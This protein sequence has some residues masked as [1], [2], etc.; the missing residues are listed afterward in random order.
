MPGVIIDDSQLSSSSLSGT[1]WQLRTDQDGAFNRTVTVCD[2]ASNGTGTSRTPPSIRFTFTGTQINLVGRPAAD[3]RMNY[4]IDESS[5]RPAVLNT[6]QDVVGKDGVVIWSL[7]GLGPTSSHTVQLFPVAGT[8]ALDYLSYLPSG[9]LAR[10]RDMLVVDNLDPQIRFSGSWNNERD[11][12]AAAGIPL[13]GTVSRTNSVGASFQFNFTGSAVT[14]YALRRSVAGRLSASYR[15]D[16]GT[17]ETVVHFNGSQDTQD[18]WSIN[19]AFF[20]KDLVPSTHSLTVTVTEVSANQEFAFDYLT[21]EATSY[22]RFTGPTPI[23][24]SSSDRSS[25]SGSRINLGAII[26]SVIAVVLIAYAVRWIFKRR[27]TYT[28]Q[29]PQNQSYHLETTQVYTQ[30]YGGQ[31]GQPAYEGHGYRQD[32]WPAPPPPYVP[33]PQQQAPL[34]PQASGWQPPSAPPPMP[35]PQPWQSHNAGE[36]AIP[37]PVV[38]H[39]PPHPVPSIP[40]I[41]NVNA[42]QPQI[43]GS[44]PT[45]PA[46][47][48]LPSLSLLSPQ[49]PPP[50]PAAV[51]QPQPR[52][53]PPPQ[54]QAQ[55]DGARSESPE[56]E[57]VPLEQLGLAPNY[58]PPAGPPPPASNATGTTT[59]N[60]RPNE[61]GGGA[62]PPFGPPGGGASS[63]QNPGPRSSL[64]GP[65]PYSG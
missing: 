44:P 31:Q 3:L 12:S 11:F 26:G 33:P 16:N 65:P 48:P 28:P 35:S 55:Q 57:E 13:N 27:N 49:P 52:A 61:P 42:Q 43:G 9:T 53:P 19:Q 36:V 41:G 7:D 40:N 8:L 64:G 58:P 56:L 30:P 22:T 62:P 54:Q 18:R 14:V 1:Q 63:G 39:Q 17:P 29:I 51:L 21:L 25:S 38:W 34:Q 4:S 5:V 45:G 50:A 47:P 59:T 15:I 10:S 20:T 32:S 60:T 46:P 6:T 23:A 24:T 37:E 2:A